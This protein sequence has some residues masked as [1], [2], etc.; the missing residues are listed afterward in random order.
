[1]SIDPVTGNPGQT[2]KTAGMREPHQ[3]RLTGYRRRGEI[4]YDRGQH[5]RSAERVD[6]DLIGSRSEPVVLILT[7]PGTAQDLIIEGA[8]FALTD[9][10]PVLAPAGLVVMGAAVVLPTL[11]AAVRRDV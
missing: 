2:R 10:N 3:T 6:R 9:V 5:G 4:E 1:M 11:V 8:L 7:E